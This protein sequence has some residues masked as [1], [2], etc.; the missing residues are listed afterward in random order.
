MALVLSNGRSP[1]AILGLCGPPERSTKSRDKVIS[2]WDGAAASSVER[3]Y[4]PT[5]RCVCWAVVLETSQVSWR[6][7]PSTSERVWAA[8]VTDRESGM[9]ASRGERNGETGEFKKT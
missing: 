6:V 7:L 5:D 3:R 2:S 8:A 9:T 4:Q 1:V